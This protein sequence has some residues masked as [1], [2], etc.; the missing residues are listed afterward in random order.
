MRHHT[1]LLFKELN[2]QR[3]IAASVGDAKVSNF[4][5][6]TL[7]VRMHNDISTLENS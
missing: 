6:H 4:T 5:S 2:L 3:L 7:L 1:C